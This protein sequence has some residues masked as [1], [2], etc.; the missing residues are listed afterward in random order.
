MR[1]TRPYAMR[2]QSLPKVRARQLSNRRSSGVHLGRLKDWLKESNMRTRS[3]LLEVIVLV[4]MLLLSVETL[5]AQSP[6]NDHYKFEVGGQFS[7]IKFG[8]QTAVNKIPYCLA[9][10]KVITEPF[11]DSTE[12]GFGGRFGYTLNRHVA[13][14]ADINF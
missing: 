14:D 4:S 6:N 13:I 11:S 8:K 2:S 5:N 1:M 9:T 3:R 7:L 12:P 10:C